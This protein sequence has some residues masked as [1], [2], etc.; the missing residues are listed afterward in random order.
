MLRA[1]PLLS[2]SAGRKEGN[3]SLAAL[4]IEAL[5]QG[6]SSPG[7][8]R[9]GRCE[10]IGEVHPA[11]RRGPLARPD[12]RSPCHLARSKGGVGCALP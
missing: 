7:P 12:R 1:S 5:P 4:I 3:L 8:L 9:R 6:A 2:S 10:L 11:S